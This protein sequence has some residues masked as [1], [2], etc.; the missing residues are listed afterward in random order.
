MSF[1]AISSVNV[2]YQPGLKKQLMGRL[3]LESR[4]IFFEYDA[5]FLKTSLQLS[6]FKLPLKPGVIIAENQPFEG[7]FGIFNDSLPDGWGRLLL[8]R[9][10]LHLGINPR[11]LSPL[12]RLCYVGHHGMGSLVYEPD[13]APSNLT[14]NKILDDIADEIVQFQESESD[15]FVDELLTLNGSSA[16]ARPKILVNI[17]GRDWMIKFRSIFDPAD[18]GSIE[19]AYHLMAKKAGL[20]VPDAMLFPSQKNRPYFGVKR[21]DREGKKRIHMHTASG[22]LQIDHRIPSMDYE[23]L[24]KITISL[25]KSIHESEKQ[26]RLAVFNVFAHNRDDHAKNFSFLMDSAG[27]WRVSPAYD[28]TFSSGPAGEHCSMVMGEGKHPCRTH[29]FKLAEFS[30]IQP[31]KAEQIIDEVSAAV[32]EWKRFADEAEVS[33]PSYSMIKNAL[34]KVIL[35]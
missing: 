19:Y 5:E 9:K 15:Y 11:Q 29:L 35:N 12:D 22:L 8:D 28:L 4:R 27:L 18:I 26:F 7:L 23:T 17:E 34:D 31:E 13:I 33:K 14:P 20:D 30:S 32:S 2:Y 21:F 3:A 6:P 24:M 16:G 25:T 1:Q 10:L